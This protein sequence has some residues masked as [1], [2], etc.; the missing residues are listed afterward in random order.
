MVALRRTQDESAPVG[1]L[2]LIEEVRTG[3]RLPRKD[4]LPEHTSYADTGCDLHAHCLTCPLVR[5]RYDE[6]GGLHQLRV[7]GRDHQ[8]L[9]LH[10]AGGLTI[11]DIACR[12]GISRRT[13]FRILARAR[14]TKEEQHDGSDC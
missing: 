8:V 1:R 14:S 5:C 4:A 6:T 11:D 10:D 12:V 9:S 13:V 2:I 7:A 3:Q